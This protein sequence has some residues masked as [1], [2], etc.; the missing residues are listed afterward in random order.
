MGEKRLFSLFLL[1]ICK[2][3]ENALQK[4]QRAGTGARKKFCKKGVDMEGAL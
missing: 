3:W 2:M 4:R 1:R